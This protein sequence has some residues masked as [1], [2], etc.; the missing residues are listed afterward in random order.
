MNQ[1]ADGGEAVP[2]DRSVRHR[3]AS[4]ALDDLVAEAE[5]LGLY[6][7]DPEAIREALKEARAERGRT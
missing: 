4:R 5:R 2:L 3:E 7:E 6:D 1:A